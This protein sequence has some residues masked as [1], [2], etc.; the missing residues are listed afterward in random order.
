ML[1]GRY[2]AVKVESVPLKS[3][4]FR[5]PVIG[6]Q[7]PDC[8]GVRFHTCYVLPVLTEL[9]PLGLVVA[10]SPLS[11]IPAVLVLHTPRPV[12][13]GLA[14]LIGWL[15][16]LVALTAVFVAISN[17]VGGIGHRPP[18]WASWLRILIGA[19]L[20]GFGIYRWLTRKRSE[21]MPGWM[22]RLS[23]LTPVTAAATGVALTA[24]NPKV[25]FLCAA[26]GLAIGSAGIDSPQ[27]WL[28]VLWFAAVAG[29]TVALP[30]LGYA[31]SGGRLD[32]ALT[33]L[34]DWMERRHATLIAA[35]LIVI[36]IMVAY[37][38]IH[39]L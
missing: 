4:F 15:V 5:V 37:K 13:T 19:A 24:V 8:P 26:A 1:V 33:R 3:N 20:I 11:I 21:H 18:N 34:K 7:V 2:N 39:A 14:F 36:G 12:A 32:A 25:L 29:S 9:I 17:L 16:G 23:T 30:I 38:G 28:A 31:V 10:L 35:I 22:T 6:L 27:V